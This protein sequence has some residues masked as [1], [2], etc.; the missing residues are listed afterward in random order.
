MPDRIIGILGGM[1]PAATGDLFREILRVTPAQKDQDHIPVLVYSNSKIPERTAAILQGGEDPFPYLVQTARVLERAGAGIILMPCNTAH[2][3]LPALQKEIGIP[4]LNMIEET[5]REFRR[6]MPSACKIGL[7][8]S[9]GTVR[10]GIYHTVFREGGV[11]VLVPDATEQ[12]RISA[13]IFDVKAAN[14]DERTRETFESVGTQLV[15]SG[16]QAVILGCTEIPLAFDGQN[17]PFPY[18]N[19]TEILARAAVDWALGRRN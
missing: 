1:G 12:A 4:I 3:F 10:S 5:L 11:E 16:A 2:F 9:L 7:L 17:A 13:A 8:A 18:L 6:R 14:H 15:S 19:P